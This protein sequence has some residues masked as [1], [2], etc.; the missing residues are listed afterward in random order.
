VGRGG[1]HE[2]EVGADHGPAADAADTML[3]VG[4]S[5]R[6]HAGLQRLKELVDQGICGNIVG[7][8][9]MVGTYFTLMCATTPYRMTEPNALIIDYTHLLDYLGLLIGPIVRV[10]A[11]SATLGDLP[12]MPKPNVFSILLTHES[13]ALSQMHADYV[14]HPQR[15]MAEVFGDEAVL[16]YDFQHYELRI[17]TRDRPGYEV[18]RVVTA[19]DDIYRVQ[20]ARFL[21]QIH[22][23]RIP[24]C[25]A[26]EGLAA[27]K[28]AMA[29]VRSAEEHRA[30]GV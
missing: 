15:S 22:G 12:M 26:R 8:R 16:S 9:A 5:L 17:F 10:S 24:I 3:T 6:S 28:A 11:E 14:Q 13:G 25:T 19:R 21:E 23:D 7:G 27:L 4:Y 30:V 2:R 18:E 1:A 29:A 20:I